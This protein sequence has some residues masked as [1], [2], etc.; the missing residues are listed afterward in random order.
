MDMAMLPFDYKTFIKEVNVAVKKGQIPQ[1]RID[2]AVSRILY[3]KFKAGLFDT[4]QTKHD[5]QTFGSSDHKKLAREAVASSAVLLKNN[6]NL[7]P[8]SKNSGKIL[9]AGSGADN[10][11]R[12]SGAWT[13]EWQGVDGNWMPGTTSI[14]QGIRQVVGD[15]SSIEYEKNGNFSQ[16]TNKASVGIVVVSEKPYAEGWGDNEN[17][18]IGQEDLNA[19]NNVKKY[20]DKVVVIILSGRPLIISDQINNWDALVEGWL[21]G[22]EGTGIADVIF[23]DH[24]FRGKLPIDW[25]ANLNQ[26]PITTTSK[27]ADNTKPLFERGFGL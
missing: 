8:L 15:K 1:S 20:S 2:D 4:D 10:V 16:T 25:P 22:S 13:V 23:G 5:F 24:Q 12:Q 27:T 9:V 6:D 11:G 19:I 14:L 21:P 26:L 3:E 17:P 18:T 7:L